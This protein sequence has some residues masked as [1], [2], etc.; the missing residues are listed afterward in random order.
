[1]ESIPA[2]HLDQC[3]LLVL[4]YVLDHSPCDATNAA[5]ARAIGRAEKSV[6][7]SLKVLRAAGLVLSEFR[8]PN[9]HTGDL[10]GRTLTTN[11]DA[12]FALDIDLSEV[13]R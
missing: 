13:T 5:I 11:T 10:S 6:Q 1:M 2:S 3:A 7:H 9:P 4:A 12:L 8:L